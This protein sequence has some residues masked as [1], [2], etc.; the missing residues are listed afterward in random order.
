MIE[1][2]EG[3]VDILNWEYVKEKDKYAIIFKISNLK[4]EKREKIIKRQKSGFLKSL[5]M[6]IEE[7][8]EVGEDLHVKEYYENEDME[9][10]TSL[11][12]LAQK[13]VIPER[14]DSE[15]E[16]DLCTLEQDMQFRIDHA[17]KNVDELRKYYN[18]LIEFL[19][20]P[21]NTI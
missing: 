8:V 15:V 11:I 13:G 19:K 5:G 7:I 1:I 10:H 16:E 17:G 9:M 14:I 18:E 12:P 21:K 4:P 20:K 6:N 3:N 2:K